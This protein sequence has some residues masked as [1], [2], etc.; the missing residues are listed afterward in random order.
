MPS[1]D[2]FMKDCLLIFCLLIST[3]TSYS[4]SN[5][6]HIKADSSRLFDFF[7]MYGVAVGKKDY[8]LAKNYLDSA[9]TIVPDLA[10]ERYAYVRLKRSLRMT[11]QL[12]QS[13]Q[14]EQ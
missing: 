5:A 2:Q 11:Q 1:K 7:R 3:S 4:Q 9:L 13:V 12:F 6:Q 8:A 14:K 10:S